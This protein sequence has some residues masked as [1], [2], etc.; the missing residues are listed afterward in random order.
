V[1]PISG[2]L[3]SRIILAALLERTEAANLH[4][5]TFGVPGCYDLEIGSQVAQA[6]GT[7]HH[8]FSFRHLNYHRDEL[9][10]VANRT[11]RQAVLFHH[12]PVWALDRLLGGCRIW[13]GYVGDAVAGSHL[14][15]PPSESLDAAKRLHLRSRTFVRSTRLFTADDDALVSRMGGGRQDPRQLSW[16]E[17]VLFDEAV[18]KFTAPLV[19]FRGFEYLTP[20][21]NSPWMDFMFSVPAEHR[22][23]Q[24]LMIDIARR[25]YSR[26]FDL[27]SKNRLGH[28]FDTSA[29][30]IRAKFWANRARK[31]A[32]RFIPAVNY[33][34]HQY[35]D[36]NEA[37]RSSPNARE[38][39]RS[40]VSDLEKRAV[41]DWIDMEALWRRHDARLANHGDALVV[42][43]SLELVLSARDSARDCAAPRPVHSA[44]GP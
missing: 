40:C 33:P 4:T 41:V 35:N 31:L 21:I 5:Y 30:R 34:N 16:D 37:I 3:D 43:A 8:A 11:G 42:L 17:Q 6:I 9:T 10:D 38:L 27:P 44:D 19:L 15:D 20:L 26:L 18:A 12:P 28:H 32:H 1:V 13:S 7:R 2:G 24:R 14:H 36:F 22:L 29:P 25:A 23:G 39:I